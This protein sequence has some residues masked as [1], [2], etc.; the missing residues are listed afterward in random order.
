VYSTRLYMRIKCVYPYV[1]LLDR[2]WDTREY[3]YKIRT[4]INVYDTRLY[5]RIKCVYPHVSLHDL[6]WDTRV[7]TY[8]IRACIHMC[9][10]T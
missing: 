1:S 8:K 6:T 9:E 10:F 7:Y 4:C 3:T 2:T 5:M